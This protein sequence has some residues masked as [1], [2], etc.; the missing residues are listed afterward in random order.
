MLHRLIT[1]LSL[2]NGRQFQKLEPLNAKAP[3]RCMTLTSKFCN[4]DQF[5]RHLLQFSSM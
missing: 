5:V 1:T 2:M 3:L 4:S